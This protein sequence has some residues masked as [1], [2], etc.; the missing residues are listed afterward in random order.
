[1]HLFQKSV[2]TVL[3]LSSFCLPRLEAKKKPDAFTLKYLCSLS[4][5]F[6]SDTGLSPSLLGFPS[7]NSVQH[8]LISV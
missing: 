8:K 1:M 3:L 2:R 5:E 4:S 6:S 7:S